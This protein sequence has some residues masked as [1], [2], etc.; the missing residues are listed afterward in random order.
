MRYVGNILSSLVGHKDSVVSSV[1]RH[2]RSGLIAIEG[3]AIPAKQLE[4]VSLVWFCAIVLFIV[5][6]VSVL[7]CFCPDF[8]ADDMGQTQIMTSLTLIW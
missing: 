3:R 4:A 8:D 1:V 7:L 2:M 6:C 5:L